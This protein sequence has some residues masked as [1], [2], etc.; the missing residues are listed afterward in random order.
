MAVIAQ[1]FGVAIEAGAFREMPILQL[2]VFGLGLTALAD[3]LGEE[4]AFYGR[5][6]CVTD[7]ADPH[8]Q[9]PS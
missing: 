7:F 1:E 4:S 5:T 2:A 3:R 8:L 6:E 9:H